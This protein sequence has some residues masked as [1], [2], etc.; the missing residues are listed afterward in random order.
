VTKTITFHDEVDD[1]ENHL[2]SVLDFSDLSEAK[3]R[4]L[5]ETIRRFARKNGIEVDSALMQ[6]SS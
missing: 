3:R 4:E 2:H 6:T 5:R 1:D